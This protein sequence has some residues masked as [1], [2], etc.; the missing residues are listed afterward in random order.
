MLQITFTFRRLSVPAL[1]MPPPSKA[2]AVPNCHVLKSQSSSGVHMEY[3]VQQ[4]TVDD[5]HPGT[6]TTNRK[7]TRDVKVTRASSVF[8]VSEC[9]ELI[10]T[11]TQL[12]DVYTR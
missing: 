10:D 9:A 12:H 2:A 1:K 6:Q 3:T 7:L 8:K 4:P 5:C 11:S